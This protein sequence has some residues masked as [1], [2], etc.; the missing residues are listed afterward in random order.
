MSESLHQRS[1]I[2]CITMLS[3]WGELL[4][5]NVKLVVLGSGWL[6]F[7]FSLSAC[8]KWGG[9]G[10][11]FSEGMPVWAKNVKNVQ[12]WRRLDHRV[13]GATFG[14][15]SSFRWVRREFQ[16]QHKHKS[17]QWSECACVFGRCAFSSPPPLSFSATPSGCPLA[18]S[19]SPDELWK[20][21]IGGSGSD[22]LA[23]NPAI[24]DNSRYRSDFPLPHVSR[25]SH[26][27]PAVSKRSLDNVTGQ[28]RLKL[29]LLGSALVR[30]IARFVLEKLRKRQMCFSCNGCAD[31]FHFHFDLFCFG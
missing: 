3:V 21:A 23:Q 17:K 1:L 11:G 8:A 10:G 2:T 30:K 25:D 12:E 18:M 5:L 19:A 29:A 20:R 6:H 13:Q 7:G 24:K 28:A 26:L 9:G 16:Q 31:F 22:V 14:R 27:T 4:L 15:Q